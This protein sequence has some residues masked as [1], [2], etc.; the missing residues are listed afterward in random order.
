LGGSVQRGGG[1]L[2]RL[3][4][5]VTLASEG[6]TKLPG[7]PEEL[8]GDVELPGDAPRAC[9]SGPAARAGAFAR[10]TAPA[11]EATAARHYSPRT[12]KAYCAWIRRYILF[13]GR[14]HPRELGPEAIEAFLTH[15]A[16]EGHVSA[17]TQNQALAALLFLYVRVL[18]QPT[19][20]LEKLVRAK[21][22]VRLPATLT[23]TEVMAVLEQMG[24][25]DAPDG[26]PAVRLGAAAPGVRLPARE[27]PRLRAARGARARLFHPALG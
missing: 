8:A 6:G 24:G 9:R 22:P 4:G 23:A 15:L 7:A 11:V 1:G 27:G 13:H 19:A 10:T 3:G 17:S 25:A 18:A 20:W 2:A 5:M 21:R 16:T 26:V 14:R 12:E